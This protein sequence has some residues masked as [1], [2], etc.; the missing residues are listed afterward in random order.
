MFSFFRK[1]ESIRIKLYF[2]DTGPI[3]EGD[4]K[5]F[6]DVQDFESDLLVIMGNQI[7]EENTVIEGEI[8][9]TTYHYF[10]CFEGENQKVSYTGGRIGFRNIFRRRKKIY[11]KYLQWV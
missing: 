10:L 4:V 9:K 3:I 5:N 7:E 8:K 6:V 1:A 2:N 11:K